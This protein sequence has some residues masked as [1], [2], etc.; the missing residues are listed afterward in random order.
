MLFPRLC[1]L[2]EVTWSP[3]TSR[4][5]EDFRRRLQTQFRRFDQLGVN[6][7]KGAPGRIGE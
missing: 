5:W 3:Q 4:N 2:A 6:H 7:R 1:A